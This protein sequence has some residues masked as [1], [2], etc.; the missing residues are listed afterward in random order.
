MLKFISHK[1]E[2]S[3]PNRSLFYKILILSL[4][5][6][7]F[8]VLTFV[9][10]I[11]PSQH[12]TLLRSLKS[13]SS[14]IIRS[15]HQ[16]TV[17]SIAIEDY[18]TVVDHCS[19]VIEEIPSIKY[20]VIT[21][22]D[23]SS[24]VFTPGKWK[25]TYLNGFWT[26]KPANIVDGK[27]M[28]S[29][30]V[31]EKVFHDTHVI[32]YSGVQMGWIHMGL[33]LDNY[34][35]DLKL[36]Y[37]QT[38]VSA[39]IAIGVGVSISFVFYNYL[40]KPIQELIAGIRRAAKG[41]LKT[42][43]HI[44]TYDELSE[45]ADFF[46]KMT[47]SLSNAQEKLEERVEQRTRELKQTNLLLEKEIAE[48]QIAEQEI[49]K[50][51]KAVETT[52]AAIC[53]TDISGKIIYVNPGL[54]KLL[55]YDSD[56]E[57]LNTLFTCSL[58][59]PNCK[60]TIFEIINELNAR[61]NW[62]GEI[63]IVNKAQIGFPAE[64]ICSIIYDENQQPKYLLGHIYDL[65]EIKASQE[66]IVESLKEKEILLKEIHHR[67]KNNLQI[68]TSL[69]YLQ[70]KHSNDPILSNLLLESQRRIK[71]M[72]LIHEKLYQS[73]NLA[74]IDFKDYITNLMHDLKRTYEN[75]GNIIQL[76]MEVESLYLDIDKAIPCGLI[77]NELVSNAYKY[78]FPDT[79]RETHSTTPTVFIK[80]L[81]TPENK[82]CLTVKDNGCGMGDIEEN[83]NTTSLGLKLV[84]SLSNQL[85]GNLSIESKQGSSFTLVF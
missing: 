11:F 66:K 37:E 30:L 62:S 44:K 15:I 65:S 1:W 51:S 80:F 19:Q 54:I 56:E 22:M 38:L 47:T 29:N 64:L 67:V 82:L 9:V 45:L 48:R 28:Y 59:H 26:P 12:A 25:F 21:R 53:M 35:K 36:V 50:L 31:S 74:S 40:N 8:T 42:K 73:S 6:I 7:L 14:S 79:W 34:E 10:A 52:P 68:I 58:L 32:S 85:N 5:V 55:G 41:D 13:Q 23:G 46:N 70:S 69:L 83:K 78:A 39:L 43:V 18:S 33:S 61:G 16:V 49:K 17:R 81:K 72:A 2:T 75:N 24:N 60:T 57:L 77:I 4:V 3:S 63:E 71:S 20:I 27:I 84:S 76:N